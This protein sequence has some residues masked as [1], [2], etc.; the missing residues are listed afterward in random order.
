MA[1]PSHDGAGL[2]H[3]QHIPQRKAEQEDQHA[4][5]QLLDGAR[6]RDGARHDGHRVLPGI[7]FEAIE[8][9]IH[10]VGG[11]AA[12][13]EHDKGVA[14]GE[15]QRLGAGVRLAAQLFAEAA[16]DVSFGSGGVSSVP[17][18]ASCLRQFSYVG[19]DSRDRV[20]HG[21][22]PAWAAAL[23]TNCHAAPVRVCNTS[24]WLR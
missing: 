4:R 7:E 11:V 15:M 8:A 10:A 2:L 23:R 17:T 12:A 21:I 13:I 5:D 20:R 1:G 16:N 22:A 3:L 9:A 19:G 18:N 6:G 24:V 14:E